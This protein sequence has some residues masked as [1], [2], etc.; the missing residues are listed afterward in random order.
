MKHRFLMFASVLLSLSS[1]G[2]LHAQQ[3]SAVSSLL[4]RLTGSTN[5]QSATAPS[6]LLGSLSHEQVALGLKQALTNGVQTAIRDLGH[7]GGFLTN[8]A[9]RIPLPK[10]LH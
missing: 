4:D 2:T 5:R 1:T 3:S 9:V 10:Q 7:D 8:V 6:G